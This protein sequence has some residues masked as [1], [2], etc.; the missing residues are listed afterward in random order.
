MQSIFRELY[1]G[2]ISPDNKDCLQDHTYQK[3]ISV[4][5]GYKDKLTATLDEYQKQ[6]P[7]QYSESRSEVDC[8]V[9]YDTF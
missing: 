5:N 1:N 8:L 7:E 3:A 2:E 6:L 9:S 4:K